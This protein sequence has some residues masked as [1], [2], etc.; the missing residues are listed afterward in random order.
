M[1]PWLR[2]LV[3]AAILLLAPG[4]PIRGAT[5]G[6]ASAVHAQDPY[7]VIAAVNALRASQGLPAYTVNSALMS[8]A[9]AHAEYMASSGNVGHTGPDGSRPY[10]RG[11]A[12]G[13]PL[14]GQIPP[15]FFS[16]NIQSGSGLTPEE[17]VQIWTGDDPH[18]HTMNSDMLQEIGAGVAV[19]DGQVYYVI[20]CARPTGSG[21][22]QAYT[23]GAA[24]SAFSVANEIIEP[25]TKSTPNAKGELIHEVLSGQSLWQIAIE[26]GVKIDQIRMLNQLPVE[27]IINPGD[28]LLITTVG[29]PT[30]VS[31]TPTLEPSATP[32]PLSSPTLEPSPSATATFTATPDRLAALGAGGAGGAIAA[33]II[34]ALAAAGLVAWAGRARPV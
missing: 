7:A 28:T 23:P 25:V 4:V 29:T 31:A 10:Q 5:A 26:Y 14:A 3:L 11:L 21:L 1:H 24:E 12:A 20:D 15:G 32:R 16:E 17:A 30:P 18:M 22:P 2:F 6:P 27:Y 33:I 9:Q 8:I 19:S 34:A 13:Y